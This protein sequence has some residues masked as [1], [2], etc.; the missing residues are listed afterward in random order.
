MTGVMKLDPTSTA[1]KPRVERTASM[2]LFVVAVEV[3]LGTVLLAWATLS[4]SPDFAPDLAKYTSRG[5]IL[6]I[7]GL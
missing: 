2:A 4:I 7:F 6:W 5:G 3:V 1:E